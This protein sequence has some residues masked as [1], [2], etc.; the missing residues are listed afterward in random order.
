M[1]VG[2]NPF[3]SPSDEG[4]AVV[5]VREG[6]GGGSIW[7]GTLGKSN[8]LFIAAGAC[9]CFKYCQQASR[10]SSNMILLLMTE[11]EWTNIDIVHPRTVFCQPQ[12]QKSNETE[13]VKCC[14]KLLAWQKS[15]FSKKRK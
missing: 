3:H 14:K 9:T 7:E 8:R 2:K 15:C 11:T 4:Q 12:L 10:T 5:E 6:V 1:S 13:T